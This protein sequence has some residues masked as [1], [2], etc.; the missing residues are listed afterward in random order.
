MHRDEI[1]IVVVACGM[2]LQ[3]TLNM[4]KSAIVFALDNPLKFVVIAETNLAT[5]FQ[6]KLDDW[7]EM[8]RQ[9]FTFEIL[10][11]TFPKQNEREWRSLFK[12]CSAQR[13]FLPVNQFPFNSMFILIQLLS[14]S[15]FAGNFK[16]C[17]FGVVRRYGHLISGSGTQYMAILWSIQWDANCRTVARAWGSQCWLVQSIR[18]SSVLWSVGRQFRCDADEFDANACIPLERLHVAAARRIQTENH[19][20]RSGFDKYF[21]LFSSRQIVCVS[22]SVQL[23]AGPLY[24]Y[25]CVQSTERSGDI[26]WQSWLLSFRQTARL[27]YY[28]SIGWR[29]SHWHRCLSQFIDANRIGAGRR[30]RETDK[31][32]QS[33]WFVSDANERRVQGVDRLLLQSAVDYYWTRPDGGNCKCEWFRQ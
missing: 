28:L 10:P 8:T 20:G 16:E 2:R 32:W 23:S 11:L 7:R 27:Q 6:E 12:P 21:I 1:I 18:P 29:V 17:W 31:L 19:V 22:V 4:L 14:M 5:A 3:E 25:E 15:R 13:L 33:Q 9:K 24:V 30:Y 26:A